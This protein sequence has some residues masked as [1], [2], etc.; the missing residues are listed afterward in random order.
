MRDRKRAAFVAVVLVVGVIERL[1]ERF[2][3]VVVVLIGLRFRQVS[4]VVIRHLRLLRLCFARAVL[5]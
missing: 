4:K 3:L 1:Q 2:I 5:K